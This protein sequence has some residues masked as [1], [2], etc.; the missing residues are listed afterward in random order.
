MKV[1]DLIV[2]GGGHAGIEAINIASQFEGVSIALVSMPGVSLGS[3]PCNPSIGGVGKGQ[4]VRELDALGGAMGILADKAGIQ[5]R[6]LNESKGF[7]VQSTR[8]QIDKEQYSLEA[9]KFIG[10]LENVDVFYE[11]VSSVSKENGIFSIKTT[12]STVFKSKTIVMTVGTFL[13]GKLHCGSEQMSGGRLDCKESD[14]LKDIFGEIN[15]LPLRFKTGTPSRIYKSSIDYSKL[16]EQPSDC[17]TR[18]FH[19]LNKP[20]SR[21]MPQISCYLTRTNAKTMEIIRSDKDNSPLFNGQIKGVGARYCPSIEDKAYRYP[22]KDIHHVFVEPEGINLDT[23]YPSGVSSSLPRGTQEKFIKTIAG[24]E[25]AV[26]KHHGYAVEYDVIDTTQLDNTLM[27]KNIEGLYFAGQVNGTSGY[28]EAAGQGFIAGVNAVLKVLNREKFVLSRRD[29][30]I[31]VMIED[32]ITNTRDE[33]Y[34]LFTARAENRL[35]IREDNAFLR[36]CPYR[37]K[38]C[39]S[40]NLDRA[41]IEIM[42]SYYLLKNLVSSMKYSNVFY[43]EENFGLNEFVKNTNGNVTLSEILKLPW[44]NPVEILSYVL[45]REEVEFN[46]VAINTVAI[47]TKYEGYITRAND[48]YAKVG[49]IEDKKINLAKILNSKNISFEC[50]QRIERI[51]PETFGQL[52]RIEGIRA[53]TL[54]VVAGGAL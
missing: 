15:T 31:G 38:L 53:A 40:T 25:N 13:N 52:R 5:F 36:M 27:F 1:Y 32:L 54:A 49:K 12:Q 17:S 42:E 16:E 23:V 51:K 19:L 47:E 3:A 28:E 44:V 9:E 33:P 48:Q 22:E 39:L 21:E 46:T 34:R 18:N 11:K 45:S 10:N 4:V 20:F 8:V 29:S 37:D 14:S 24:L 2:V 41:L 26:I 6:T 7:A 30:Y 50:K 35:F 43:V